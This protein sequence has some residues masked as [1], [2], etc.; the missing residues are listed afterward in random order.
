MIG[1]VL[2]IAG[3]SI[4]MGGTTVWLTLGRLVQ[5]TAAGVCSVTFG[6]FINENL[7]EALSARFCTLQNAG[8]A[9]GF[10][11]CYLMGGLL[12]TPEDT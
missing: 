8:I 2:G 1:S 5:G 10:I 3:G 6:K 4:S 9:V 12:P 11:P 7:P